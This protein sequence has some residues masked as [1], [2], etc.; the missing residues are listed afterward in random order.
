MA[1]STRWISKILVFVSVFFAALLALFFYIF[2]ERYQGKNEISL[3]FPVAVI[4]QGVPTLIQW[5]QYVK[6]PDSYKSHLIANASSGVF[7]TA[8]GQQFSLSPLGAGKVQLTVSQSWKRQS[9]EY[10]IEAEMVKPLVFRQFDVLLLWVALSVAFLV[11]AIFY[12]LERQLKR[13]PITSV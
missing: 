11:T 10:A 7:T 1:V 8:E 5:K 13:T 2:A 9:A 6:A 12:F 4:D 3:Q